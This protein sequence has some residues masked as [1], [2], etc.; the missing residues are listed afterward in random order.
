MI[1]SDLGPETA[2]RIR[3]S[4]WQRGSFERGMEELGIRLVVAEEIAKALANPLPSGWRSPPFRVP[5]VI[6]VIGVNG[7]GK[8]TTIAKLA[9]LFMEQDYSA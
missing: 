7:S 4:D 5:Q 9:H 1:A 8:T 3:A 2:S 6:L